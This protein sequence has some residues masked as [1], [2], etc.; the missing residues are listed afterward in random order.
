[1]QVSWHDHILKD[2]EVVVDTIRGH[3]LGQV[4]R[5]APLLLALAIIIAGW[6]FFLASKAA[7]IA[8]V[9]LIVVM[10]AYAGAMLLLYFGDSLVITN[11]RL[12][13]YDQPSLFKREVSE[14]ELASI[15]D[16]TYAINGF[17]Q[18]LLNVGTI[19]VD[20]S[21]KSTVVEIRNIAHPAEIQSLIVETRRETMKHRHTAQE[22][23][24]RAIVE[25]VERLKPSSPQDSH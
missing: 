12:I 7:F 2:G 23:A 11:Q 25:M 24:A 4:K 22:E 10:I 1:M 18:T 17:W 21:S 14:I 8:L 13:D 3:W 6:H 16:V 15:Q 20:T 19:N 5:V 9:I